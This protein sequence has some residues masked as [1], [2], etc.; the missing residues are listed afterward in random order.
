[1]SLLTCKNIVLRNKKSMLEGKDRQNSV[2]S[3]LKQRNKEE[4]N[5]KATTMKRFKNTKSDHQ[6]LHSAIMLE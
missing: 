2:F 3:T 1:M 5:K 4:K 6:G